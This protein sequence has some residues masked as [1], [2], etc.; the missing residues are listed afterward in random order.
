VDVLNVGCESLSE[1]ED[2]AT[3]IRQVEQ[4]AA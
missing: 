2:L 1:V 4:K 3:N